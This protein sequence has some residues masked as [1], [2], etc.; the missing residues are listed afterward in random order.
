MKKLFLL[1]VFCSFLSAE[2]DW[3]DSNDCELPNHS[4]FV[5]KMISK[6]SLEQKIGQ[7]I[8]P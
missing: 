6:M 1:I 7:I 2:I 8:M 3:S 5:N 4:N